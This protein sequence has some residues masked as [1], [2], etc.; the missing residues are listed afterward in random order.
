ML[1]NLVI[2]CDGTKNEFGPENTNVVRL[3]QALDRDPTRQLIYYDPGIGTL[4]EP[5]WVSAAGKKVSEILG[6]AFG[7]GLLWKV[8][9]AYSYLMDFWE[10]G[11]RVFLFGFSRGA[12]SVRVLA[13]LLH[14]LGLLPRGNHNLVPYLLRLFRAAPSGQTAESIKSGTNYWKLSNQFR[15]TFARTVTGATDENRRFVIHFLG[16]W[17]TVSSVGWVWDPKS[18]PYTS[19]NPSVLVVRHAIAIDERRAFF[20]QNRL[21]PAEGQDLKEYWFPGVHADIGGGYPNTSEDGSLWKVPFEWM[22]EQARE[23]HLLID[24]DRLT[25]LIAQLPG[26]DKPW[27]DS[28][29]NS[30]TLAWLPAEC[31]PKWHW[32][33]DRQKRVL[34]LGMGRSRTIE[35]GAMIHWSALRRIRETNYSPRNMSATFLEKVGH[36][37][38]QLPDAM[39]YED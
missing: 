27:N 10:P 29:H 2:C 26:S 31:F 13:A 12:Y 18:F 6:L 24:N 19:S 37:A 20:R 16:I 1:K 39:P 30:M 32:A 38:T 7:A 17:D 15:K 14:S 5:G 11:D 36:H 34:R 4:P 3:I 9:A 21:F 22:I 8:G 23:F 35:K 28:I 33:A 25:K